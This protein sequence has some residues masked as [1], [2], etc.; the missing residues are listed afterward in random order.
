MSLDTGVSP[1]HLSGIMTCSHTEKGKSVHSKTI[2]RVTMSVLWLVMLIISAGGFTWQE[3]EP[4]SVVNGR[5]ISITAFQNRVQFE[6]WRIAGQI[7]IMYSLTGGDL[8]A[9]EPYPAKELLALINPPIMGQQVL[10]TMEEDVVLAQ[11]AEDLGIVVDDADVD[12]LII[13]QMT[14]SQFVD[15]AQLDPAEAEALLTAFFEDFA[16]R[17]GLGEETVREFYYYTLIRVAMQAYLIED[18]PTEELRVKSRHILLAFGAD[19]SASPTEDQKADALARANEVLVA[20]QDGQSFA[21]LA[22]EYSD[23]PGTAAT[24]GELGWANPDDF[25]PAF[26]DAVI[27]A[28]I[29]V[30]AGP[31]ETQFGYHIILVN[32]RELQLLTEQ[33]LIM[34][35]EQ[36]MH[37]WLDSEMANAEIERH[38]DWLDY[39]PETPTYDE[40]LGDIL[41]ND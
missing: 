40:L 6:R 39:V 2:I 8:N 9:I 37:N 12:E 15:T 19:F 14:E 5:P 26:R 28:E 41:P 17:T 24:G 10:K 13:K 16:N 1:H 21:D 3:S 31:V 33:E 27:A 35:R 7:R 36:V 25:V 20:L 22:T 38:P 34:R 23:D 30:A 18:L 11:A 32:D 4:V 29:G